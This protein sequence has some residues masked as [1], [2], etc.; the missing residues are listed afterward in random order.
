MKKKV[1]VLVIRDT[2][3]PNM[4]ISQV[5]SELS[6][7]EEEDRVLFLSR[8]QTIEWTADFERKGEET[9][10]DDICFLQVEWFYAVLNGA[11]AVET[12]DMWEIPSV[13]L[14]PRFKMADDQG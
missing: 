6:V 4:T 1:Y 11:D 9:F 14:N 8:R 5:E 7:Y 2:P 10:G 12:C 3:S 13:T